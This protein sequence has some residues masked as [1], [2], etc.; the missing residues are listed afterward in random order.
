MQ[1]LLNDGALTI[2][3]KRDALNALES[4]RIQKINN[5]YQQYSNAI[6]K[7]ANGQLDNLNRKY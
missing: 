7:S 4:K 6:A 3:G 2:W 5:V 1:Q